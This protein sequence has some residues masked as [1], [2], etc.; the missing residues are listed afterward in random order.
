MYQVAEVLMVCEN[1]VVICMDLSCVDP[2]LCFL[3]M[4]N[5]HLKFEKLKGMYAL[6]SKRYELGEKTIFKMLMLVKL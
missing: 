6:S 4:P 5:V 2:G 1:C 3:W